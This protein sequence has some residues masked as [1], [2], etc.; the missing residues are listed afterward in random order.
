MFDFADFYSLTFLNASAKT[1][2]QQSPII[3]ISTVEKDI[4]KNKKSLKQ[5][6]YLVNNRI[7]LLTKPLC[8]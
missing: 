3:L 5:R 6:K 7:K 4:Q 1:L 8:Q 2:F